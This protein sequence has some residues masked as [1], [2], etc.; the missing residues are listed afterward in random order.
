MHGSPRLGFLARFLCVRLQQT[1][2]E[3]SLRLSRRDPTLL[4]VDRHERDQ[5]P[6]KFCLKIQ[7]LQIK[8]IHPKFL[9]QNLLVT[10]CSMF[11]LCFTPGCQEEC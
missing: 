7:I 10:P 1:L 9:P 4:P 8:G 11:L 2:G 6:G 3:V 5:I